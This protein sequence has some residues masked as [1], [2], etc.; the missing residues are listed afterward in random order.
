[1]TTYEQLAFGRAT[2]YRLNSNCTPR[3][4]RDPVLD[5]VNE[6][7]PRRRA[8]SPARAVRIIA[9]AP[10]EQDRD[11]GRVV[12]GSKPRCGGPDGVDR[13]RVGQVLTHGTLL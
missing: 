9:L 1:L 11:I 3:R 6:Q 12:A 5:D 8:D 2:R 7:L 10:A 4:T 13:F